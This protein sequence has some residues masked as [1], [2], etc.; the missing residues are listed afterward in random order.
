MLVVQLIGQLAHGRFS[1]LTL[2]V[3]SRVP[4]AECPPLFAMGSIGGCCQ[5]PRRGRGP[6]LR[7]AAWLSNKPSVATHSNVSYDRGIPVDRLSVTVPSEL[8]AALRALADARGKTVSALVTDAIADEI[9]RAALDEAV[10]AAEVRFG[11]ISEDLVAEAR[12]DL[13]SASRKTRPRRS[14]KRA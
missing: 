2:A 8:G 4:T 14:R 5:S 13:V 12:R 10:A 1:T 3:I 6:R 7:V 9:R 11:P